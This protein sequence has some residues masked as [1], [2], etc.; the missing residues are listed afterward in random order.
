[1]KATIEEVLINKIPFV[2]K[3]LRI[4]L[5]IKTAQDMETLLRIKSG[6]GCKVDHCY[7]CSF[8]FNDSSSQCY[9]QLLKNGEL[10]KD[11]NIP[12]H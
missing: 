12:V 3:V 6:I 11:I 2:S 8:K 9:Q 7:N 5:P 4:E 1:M 10:L